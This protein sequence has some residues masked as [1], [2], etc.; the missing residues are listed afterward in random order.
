M[1]KNYS[2]SMNEPQEKASEK[3]IKLGAAFSEVRTQF[4]YIETIMEL[5]HSS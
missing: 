3:V 1:L 2:P 4:S 5:T